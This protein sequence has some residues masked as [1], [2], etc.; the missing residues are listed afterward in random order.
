MTA[1]A[2]AVVAGEASGEMYGAQLARALRQLVPE[3]TL[4][5]IGGERMRE[6]GVELVAHIQELA[7]VGIT[8]VV[9]HLP[10]VYQIFRRMA[11][12]IARRRPALFIPID[13]PDFNLRLA[14]KSKSRGI[15]VIYFISPQIWAW[16]KGRLAT[17]RRVVDH[18]ISIFPF[19]EPFYRAA[20]IP[21]TYV[22]HPLVE[23]VHTSVSRGDFQVRNGLAADRKTICLLPGSRVREI[24][25][26]LPVMLEAFTRVAASEPVQATIA[27]A[28]TI[29][30]ALI[31]TF[32]GHPV[33]GNTK[34]TILDNDTYAG[35]AH[36]D[37]AVVASGT[38]TVEAV[39]LGTPM[40][41]VYRVSRPTW[42]V[43]KLLVE[44][45][46]YS[47]VNLIAGR[48]VVP[49]LIQDD[50]TVARVASEVRSLLANE[51]KRKEMCAGMAEVRQTLGAP[52]AIERAARLIAEQLRVR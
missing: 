24:E 23:I 34:I 43:G 49:E 40:V 44:T 18:V 15:P 9:A 33:P 16:R 1:P 47:M 42:W 45:P 13:F 11:R 36:A 7:V 14:R 41:V 48:E 46:F 5:G 31:E 8:E 35:L 3:V 26:H 10:R 29:E 27:R 21:V 4:F 19:E 39:L 12:E 38:A 17:M 50:F 20:G 30:R 22:G 25:N 6:A 2:V 28:P 37:V 52:G 32:L 51:E